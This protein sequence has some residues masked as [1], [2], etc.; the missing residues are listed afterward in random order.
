MIDS[1][2]NLLGQC[3]GKASLFRHH[4]IVQAKPARHAAEFPGQGRRYLVGD[5][6]CFKMCSLH[7]KYSGL[8]VGLEVDAGSDGFAL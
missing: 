5:G 1:G 6:A 8:A 2:G 7:T 3:P 4:D